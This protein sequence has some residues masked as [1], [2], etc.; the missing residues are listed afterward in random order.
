MSKSAVLA[1]F[2]AIF[3]ALC[4]FITLNLNRVNSNFYELSG[5]EISGEQKQSVEDFN[6]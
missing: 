2:G 4:A 5:I 3:I 1:V 6:R